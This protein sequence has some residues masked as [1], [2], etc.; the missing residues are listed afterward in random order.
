M[1]DQLRISA[2]NLANLLFKLMGLVLLL[3][4]LVGG[5]LVMDYRHTIDSPL[6]VNAPGYRLLIPP[7]AS[8]RHVT[9][10]MAHD[11][12]LP[13]PLYLRWLAVLSGRSHAI[14][15]GEYLL[16]PGTTPRQLLDRVVSGAVLEHSLTVVEGWTFAQLMEALRQQDAIQHTLDGVIPDQVMARLG[17]PGEHPEG[18]FLPDTYHFPRGTTDLAFLQR[19]FQAMSGDLEEEWRAREQGLPY[20]SAYEA[21][22]IASIIEKETALP[23]ERAEIA[24]V[25]VRRLVRGMRL[26]TDPTV[27]YGLGARFDGNLT[28]K[29]L[30]TNSL[31]NTYMHAGLPPTPIALPGMAS[32]HA[33]LH[34]AAG[35]ALYF[36]SRGDGSHVFSA[37]LAE[38]NRAVRHFQI[39]PHRVSAK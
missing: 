15:A 19:A 17:H 23:D 5:W 11:G 25:F 30:A 4:S 6:P 29:D 34:P 33:A 14:K 1:Q 27:I 18:R 39:D 24:G 26:Q 13:H 32:I 2:V 28:R 8:L 38:H 37:T 31:Y 36:V 3:G 12:V 16:E 35:D 7:G 21:L 9:A 10:A 20:H 22:I